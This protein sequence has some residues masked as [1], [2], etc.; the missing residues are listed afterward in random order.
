M[1]NAVYKPRPIKDF[2]S[3]DNAT[4][5]NYLDQIQVELI[6]LLE[7]YRRM[8]GDE[9]ASKAEAWMH[10]TETTVT[11]RERDVELSTYIITSE[12]LRIRGRIES[13][14]EERD[15]LLYLLGGQVGTNPAVERYGNWGITA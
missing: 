1:T 4:R 6:P 12:I 8:Q 3:S 13:L 15:Y 11:G 7:D 9:I 5:L 14:K 2:A 10:S